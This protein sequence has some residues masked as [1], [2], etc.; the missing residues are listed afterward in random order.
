MS[1][2]ALLLLLWSLSFSA[3]AAARATANPRP[4]SPL[5]ARFGNGCQTL[6]PCAAIERLG[7]YAGVNLQASLSDAADGRET[8]L[9][10]TLSLGLDLIRRLALEAH[11]PAAAVQSGGAPRLL[12]A[13]PL[14][15]GARLRLGPPAPT[16]FTDRPPPR[17]SLVLG[18]LLAFR[19]PHAAGDPRHIGSADLYVPQP[20]A[21]AAVELSLGPAQL[22]P[23][24]G[25]LG[26]QDAAY[27]LIGLRVSMHLAR[28]L[29]VDVEALSWLP[30]TVP[31]EP[32]RCRGG[33]RAALGV[34][35]RLAQGVLGALQYSVGAGSC[36]PGH[37]VTAGATF[38]FGEHPLRRLPTPEEAGVQ[39]LWLG[40][41]DPVLDCNGWMLD[42]QSLLPLFKY[43][44]P[45]RTDPTLIR[46]GEE[47]FRVGDH[48]D[49]DRRGRVY[50]PHQYVALA[51]EQ[52]F[53]PAA[54]REKL[55]LPE[56]SVGPRHRFHTECRLLRDT[57]RQAQ[58][59]ATVDR[60]FGA[61][62]PLMMALQLDRRCV[63]EEEIAEPH[64]L[65]EE[66]SAA[67]AAA[68]GSGL[69]MGTQAGSGSPA[70]PAPLGGGATSVSSRSSPWSIKS[71]SPD[72]EELLRELSQTGVKHTP[73]QV[74]RIARR[75]D[76]QIVFLE[77]GDARS[78]LQHVLDRHGEDFAARG[79]PPDKVPDVIMKALTEGRNLGSQGQ[80]AG[81]PVYQVAVDGMTQF[82]SITVGNNGYVVGANPANRAL[83]DKLVRSAK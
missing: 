37:A 65:A 66:L 12:A 67:L 63:S 6:T 15:V 40:I 19:L 54:V 17:A 83:V 47:S 53:K 18:T 72:R 76:G 56:C 38:A 32:G 42:E 29:R 8:A 58:G 75:P 3:A 41:V 24:A 49:I 20:S 25:V 10:G 71:S 69:G 7:L 48:F 46:R 59:Y 60:L 31:D 55:A 78:G 34:R 35:A 16:F 77:Q 14:T 68:R 62:A 39:R 27:F 51:D 21:Y 13:G 9:G 26:E 23:S 44:D 81:R 50:R 28:A 79:I 33:S 57:L 11:F 30:A 74:V 43:G 45:D 64:R 52:E 22:T 4:Q 1:R 73:D 5:A 61:T 70:G 80:G 82:I 36:E 2:R